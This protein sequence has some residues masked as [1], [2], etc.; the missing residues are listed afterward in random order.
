M[1]CVAVFALLSAAC[2]DISGPTTPSASEPT[3]SESAPSDAGEAQPDSPQSEPESDSFSSIVPTSPGLEISV[4]RVSDGDSVR[5]TSSEGD[6]EIRLIGINAPEADECFGERS[7]A[8][9]SEALDAEVIFLHPWPPELDDFG[10]ELGFLVADGQFVNLSLIAQGAAVARAQ[11]D[12]EF[13][14]DFEEVER[15]AASAAVGLWAP[16]ACGTP[17][18]AQLAIVDAEANAP[19]N[20]Q[21]NPNGEWIE[22]ENTGGD[23]IS[24]TGWSLRDESTRHRYKFPDVTINAGQRV[25]VFTGCGNDDLASVPGELFWC[26]PEPPVWN[27]DGDTAF[28]LDPNGS[29][30]ATR[31]VGG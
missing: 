24:M 14:G 1:T 3:P 13:A 30:A 9:L 21:E 4:D 5:A 31:S 12:H 11:G 19:G 28:L 2:A 18:E 8:I 20:D 29:F 7:A 6:L 10:R 23:S 17:T 25:R 16:D 15:Q 22:I 26:D 27:N